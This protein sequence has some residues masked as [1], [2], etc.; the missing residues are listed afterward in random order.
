MSSC[1]ASIVPEKRPNRKGGRGLKHHGLVTE[2]HSQLTDGSV[3]V[4][5]EL[6]CQAQYLSMTD[7]EVDR[8]VSWM[9]A[10]NLSDLVRF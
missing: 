4:D 9:V 1:E 5:A 8:R 7:V 3:E 10:K 2:Q 6:V